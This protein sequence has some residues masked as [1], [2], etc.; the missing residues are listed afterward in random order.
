MTQGYKRGGSRCILRATIS[1]EASGTAQ[2]KHE[3]Q[4]ADL[5]FP[6]EVGWCGEETN[7]SKITAV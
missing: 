2:I 4:E 6:G 5:V 1:R 7:I 3:A